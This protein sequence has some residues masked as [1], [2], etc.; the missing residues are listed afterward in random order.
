MRGML[1]HTPGPE[2]ESAATRHPVATRGSDEPSAGTE[3]VARPAMLPPVRDDPR[4]NVASS[5]TAETPTRSDLRGDRAATLHLLGSS[6]FL[7]LAGIVFFASLVAMRFPA[8]FSGPLSYGRL[9][10]AAFVAALLGWLVLGLAGGIYYVLPRLTGSPLGGEGLA[11][12][13]FWATAAVTLVGMAAVALGL[14]DGLEPFSLPWYLD[15]AVLAVLVVPGVVTIQTLRRR[16]EPNTYVTIWY[17]LAGAV[18]LPLL[19]LVGNLPGLGA[20]GRTLQEATF[21]AGF[22]VLWVVG[23]GAGLAFFVVAKET[24]QPLASRRLAKV[25]FWSLVFTAFWWGQLQ[26]VHGPTPD[27]VGAVALVMTLALPLA[28][29][30]VGF[31]LATTVGSAWPRLGELPAS[32]SALTASAMWLA[33]S[34]VIVAAG[35]R[36]SAALVGLT[37]LWDGVVYGLVFGVGG[38]FFAAVALRA[39]PAVSGRQL[40]SRDLAR[41]YLRWTVGGVG[42]TVTLFLLAGL[43]A[44]YGWTGGSFLGVVADTGTGWDQTAALVGLLSGLAL[45]TAAIALGGQLML[46]INLYRTVTSG[47]AGIGEVLVMKE[48]NR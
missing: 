30:A 31:D 40:F 44:G 32:A 26:L 27:W 3:G 23:V 43:A 1:Y 45:L 36:S 47:R 13:G 37:L 10:P 8:L 39:V 12:A 22:L 14:G 29:L 16:N 25:G 11:I 2:A 28:A 15:I 48:T 17:V 21:L 20:L 9:R 4:S 7:A 34:T 33:L 35:L 6:L 5:Q 42:G 24:D 19:Y 46:V 38:L 18:L 41:R